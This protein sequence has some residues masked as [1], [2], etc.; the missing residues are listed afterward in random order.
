MKKTLPP[1]EVS[2]PVV[3]PAGFVSA[4]RRATMREPN[5]GLSVTAM[6]DLLG[7]ALVLGRMGRRSARESE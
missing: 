3:G 2:T 5:A 1:A 6:L 7:A 4:A